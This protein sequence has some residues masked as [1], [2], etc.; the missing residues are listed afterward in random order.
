ME[1]VKVFF[2]G[3]IWH[4]GLVKLGRDASLLVRRQAGTL[5]SSHPRTRCESHYAQPFARKKGAKLTDGR[6]VGEKS[7]N[8]INTGQIWHLCWKQSAQR[9]YYIKILLFIEMEMLFYSGCGDEQEDKEV[10]REAK[11]Q[12]GRQAP[13]W[14]VPDWWVAHLSI[15]CFFTVV[16][17]VSKVSDEHHSPPALK[18]FAS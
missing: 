8:F 9:N 3:A 17:L 13:S 4:Q 11:D 1:S 2:S 15:F 14:P 6:C 7:K 12:R 5:E 16:V 18:M 10:C